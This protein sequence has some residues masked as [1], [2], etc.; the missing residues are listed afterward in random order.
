[1]NFSLHPVISPVYVFIVLMVVGWIPLDRHVASGLP[2]KSFNMRHQATQYDPWVS[3]ASGKT[4]PR[5]MAEGLMGNDAISETL[6]ILKSTKKKKWILNIC[7]YI[8]QNTYHRYASQ[9]KDWRRLN[10]RK[11]TDHWCAMCE[12]ADS[13][14]KTCI[15]LDWNAS[16]KMTPT[17]LK[18]SGR[19]SILSW[20]DA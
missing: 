9:E 3:W 15:L 6:S 14:L 8:Q 2:K 10:E 18:F 11:W 7:I 5:S 4:C 20:S 16:C 17:P 13:L 19:N 12:L 1:M